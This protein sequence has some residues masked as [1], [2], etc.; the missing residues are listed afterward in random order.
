MKCYEYYSSSKK[1]CSKI[2]CRYYVKSKE[3]NNCVI[4]KA[5]EG[6]STL[7]D[8]GSLFGI[9]RMRVCQI[10]KTIINKIKKRALEA[11]SLN[12]E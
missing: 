1:S 3:N 8:I 12:V 9:T 4:S 6:V 5:Q 2:N 7:Q 10:E 11:L